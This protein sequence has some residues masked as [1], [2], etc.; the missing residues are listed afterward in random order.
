MI[1]VALFA[2]GTGT[3]AI[4]L[5]EAAK[6]LP[7]IEIPLV[8]VDQKTSALLNVLPKKYPN[9]R[10]CLIEAPRVQ[11]PLERKR[12]H[13][14][15]MLVHLREYRIDWCFLAG[16]MRL[17]GPTLLQAFQGK[18]NSRIVNMHPS[19]LPAYPGLDAYER[20]Y[21]AGDRI[22]GVTI[23]LVDSGVDTGPVI[24]QRSFERAKLDTLDTFIE[25]G[26]QL[27]WKMYP[28][29]LKRLNDQGE[30]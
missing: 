19:L 2:S 21:R 6:D 22:S 9:L 12:L 10:V 7:N 30:L 15:E 5:L 24:L 11:N 29:I 4:K 17:I 3:N 13:E 1:R 16:Y 14:S 20:A 23:H 27:E 28:E 26:K 18:K 25:R 8:I